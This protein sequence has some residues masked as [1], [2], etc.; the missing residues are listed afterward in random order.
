ML[1]LLDLMNAHVAEAIATWSPL[2]RLAEDDPLRVLKSGLVSLSLDRFDV[3]L[4]QLNRG[5]ALNRQYPLVNGYVRAVIEQIAPRPDSAAASGNRSA[6]AGNQ[7]LVPDYPG[8]QT[9]H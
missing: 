8:G 4:E 6:Q 9:L 3:A 5:L 2:D 1:G 7:Q